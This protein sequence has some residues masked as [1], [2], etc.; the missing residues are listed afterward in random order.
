MIKHE[1]SPPAK[2]S[3]Q[4][5]ERSPRVREAIPIAQ[6]RAPLTFRSSGHPA[7]DAPCPLFTQHFRATLETD[8]VGFDAACT[9][10]LACVAIICN[11]PLPR[12]RYP[13]T[14]WQWVLRCSEHQN[15]IAVVAPLA[16][17]RAAQALRGTPMSSQSLLTLDAHHTPRPLPRNPSAAP[18]RIAP[19]PVP[20]RRRAPWVT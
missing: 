2:S 20:R 15:P 8:C 17:S 14:G 1:S 3:D 9:D 13:S 18:P 4:R 6:V 11:H 19:A 12:M 5:G 16:P 10:A 7:V